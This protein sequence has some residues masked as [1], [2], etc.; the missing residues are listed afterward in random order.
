MLLKHVTIRHMTMKY[1]HT[2]T[3]FVKAQK[4]DPHGTIIQV[5]NTQELNDPKKVLLTW[6]K[7]LHGLVDKLN[8]TETQ[9]VRKKPKYTIGLKEALLV[10]QEN[11]HPED[12]LHENGLHCYSLQPS[13]YKKTYRL[14]KVKSSPGNWVMH[15]LC[16]GPERAFVKENLMIIPE[17]TEL[18]PD[19]VQKW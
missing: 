8:D 11:Y 10:N 19:S 1:R 2:H 7:H 4:E 15:H 9:M 3:A 12:T 18:L 16:D 6:V 17:G 14:S 5:Q 13:G